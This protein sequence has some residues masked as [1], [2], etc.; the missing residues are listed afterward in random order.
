M[1]QF[2]TTRSNV[3]DLNIEAGVI[4][5]ITAAT[6]GIFSIAQPNGS[7][8]IPD[9]QGVSADRPAPRFVGGS[10][11]N[12]VIETKIND[13][14]PSGWFKQIEKYKWAS[15][16]GEFTVEVAADGGLTWSDATDIIMTAPP[17]SIPLDDRITCSSYTGS[18]GIGNSQ[19]T[20]DLGSATGLVILEFDAYGVPDIFIVEY[21]GVEVINTGYRGTSG[22]Y[23][24]V[25]VVV[26]GPG[27]G[28]ATFTKSTASPST[29]I[30]KVLAPFT[31]TAW[32][33]NLG[34]PA[35][36]SPPYTPSVTGRK[37]FTASSTAYGQTLNGGTAFTQSVIYEG[38]ESVTEIEVTCDALGGVLNFT[39]NT[40]THWSDVSEDYRCD[41]SSAGVATI[42]DHSQVI[43]TRPTVAGLEQYLDP[44]GSYEATAYGRN[45]YNNGV[46]FFASVSM[47][48]TPPLELY[49]YVKAA[50]TA[51]SITGVTGPFSDPTLPANT[52]G[53]KIIPISYSDGAGKVTQFSEGA[54]LW[55]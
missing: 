4:I 26:A 38:K 40:V 52:S 27:Y 43:A 29:C 54:I 20:V 35:A 22:T 17:G 37:T 14:I 31:G 5:D 16:V 8:G 15:E 23:D 13:D 11:R 46:E 21:N 48:F 9:D 18:G 1:S 47:N 12:M 7:Q 41:I 44:S 39:Q 51:G 32:E 42:S 30:V 55:K 50:V 6:T 10:S 45:T 25:V 2:S 53:V 28:T 49:T 33:F 19:Y 3:G 36:G 24:G 34:C